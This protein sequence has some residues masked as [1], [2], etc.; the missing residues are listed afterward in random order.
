MKQI[1][2]LDLP[3]KHNQLIVARIF[4]EIR[5]DNR[6]WCRDLLSEGKRSYRWKLLN[7]KVRKLIKQLNSK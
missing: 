4:S 1:K 6:Y 5:E 2:Q 3:V 7:T